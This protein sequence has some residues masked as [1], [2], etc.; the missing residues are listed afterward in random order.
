MGMIILI[1]LVVILALV[2][3]I[4]PTDEPVDLFVK[5][6]LLAVRSCGDHPHGH[7]VHPFLTFTA[8]DKFCL[9]LSAI[10]F[11]YPGISDTSMCSKSLSFYL[12]LLSL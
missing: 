10:L 5:L 1:V 11:P 12:C 4:L 9:W 2:G 3:P 7:I 6:G 8:F